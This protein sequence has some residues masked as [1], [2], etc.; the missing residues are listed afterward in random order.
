MLQYLNDPD[1]QLLSL[2]KYPT[3][4]T[5]FYR[6]NTC[7]P[8]PS[9]PVER[10]FSFVE[11]INASRR[12]NLSDTIFENWVLLEANYLN[13]LILISLCSNLLC[14]LR[15]SA[16]RFT[17]FYVMEYIFSLVSVLFIYFFQ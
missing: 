4:R 13:R 3:I 11:I 7:L 1:I 14:S 12:S 15:V 10:L 2:N 17:I 8:S 9:A 16:Y 5:L 6:Y